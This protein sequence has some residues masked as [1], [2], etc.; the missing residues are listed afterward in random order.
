MKRRSFVKGLAAGSAVAGLT[1]VASASVT[2]KTGP[3]KHNFKLKYAPHFG[4]F[5]NHAGKDPIDQLHFMAETGF[6]AL[7]DNG[8][9]VCPHLLQTRI[10]EPLAK[11]DM[12]MGVFVVVKGVNSANTLASGK[13]EHEYIFL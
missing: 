11:M 1:G 13:N 6:M 9:M 10:G 12:T 7:E 3:Q 5:Q 4:M 8:M 2:T